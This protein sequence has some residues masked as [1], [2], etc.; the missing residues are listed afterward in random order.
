MP[1]RDDIW[2]DLFVFLLFLVPSLLAL[3]RVIESLPG[4]WLGRLRACSDV[5]VGALGIFLYAT[6]PRP[7]DLPAH[8][9]Y[10]APEPPKITD[11]KEHAKTAAQK[12]REE[13]CDYALG[14]AVIG[15]VVLLITL[16][17]IHTLFACLRYAGLPIVFGMGAALG[18][19]IRFR[20]WLFRD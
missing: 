20:L 14:M 17:L 9:L 3:P 16:L 6:A 8:P 18:R 19:E 15:G 12:W 4:D 2:G 10:E 1:R 13:A 7:G 5:A 11:G